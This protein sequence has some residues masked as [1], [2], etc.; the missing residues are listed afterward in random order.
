MP[1]NGR[2]GWWM[3]LTVFRWV[4][5]MAQLRPS[6][7]TGLSVL[8]RQRERSAPVLEKLRRG[9]EEERESRKLEPNSGLGGAVGYLLDRWA[10]LTQFLKVP[11][12]PWTTTRPNDC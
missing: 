8:R 2:P 4:G 7:S 11:W 9:F 1:L 3:M 10:T 6:K 5:A 12:R